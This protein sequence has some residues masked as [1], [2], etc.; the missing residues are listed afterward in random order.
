MGFPTIIGG[1][2]YRW[3]GRAIRTVVKNGVTCV[4]M[5]KKES[6]VMAPCSVIGEKQYKVTITASKNSGNGALLV[7][8]FGGK[9]FDG[10]A[11]REVRGCV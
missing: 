7:N 8:F 10:A 6:I 11:V 3:R 5:P 2:G 4:T 9:H 1:N